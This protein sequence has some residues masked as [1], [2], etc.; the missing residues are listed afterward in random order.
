[1]VI[2]GFA[3]NSDAEMYQRSLGINV[4]LRWGIVLLVF[5]AWM[6]TLAWLAEPSA[7]QAA[8]AGAEVTR[9]KAQVRQVQLRQTPD[10]TAVD[11]FT[12][13]NANGLIAKVTNYGTIITELHV[14]D[15][16][17]KSGRHRAGLRQPGAVSQG[18]SLLRLHRRASG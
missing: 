1:M 10:G 5:G 13:A 14:P 16:E 8:G 12:L 7:G 15:R 9:M 18:P 2:Y 17:G 3:T 11:L 6:L 4:N